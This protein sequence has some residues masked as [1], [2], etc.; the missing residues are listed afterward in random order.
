MGHKGIKYK[1][2]NTLK[3]Y[4]AYRWENSNK[5]RYNSQ[6]ISELSSTMYR[7][8][9]KSGALHCFSKMT[10]H[11]FWGI[12]SNLLFLYFHNTN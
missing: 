11:P 9:A 10:F 3:Y 7:R 2:N 4:T 8:R 5:D 6:Y 12:V 1:C